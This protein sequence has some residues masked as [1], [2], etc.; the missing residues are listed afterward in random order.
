MQIK[1]RSEDDASS[2][3]LRNHEVTQR[4]NKELTCSAILNTRWPCV[5]RY[6]QH[7]WQ[8]QVSQHPWVSC[9]TVS[10]SLPSEFTAHPHSDPTPE[11]FFTKTDPAALRKVLKC[12]VMR[13]TGVNM[14]T[15]WDQKHIRVDED[16]MCW[17]FVFHTIRK[18][19]FS[20]DRLNLRSVTETPPHCATLSV[21]GHFQT[22][23]A[24]LFFFP[25]EHWRRS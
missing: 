14:G 13:M 4:L 24:F 5:T 16:M 6:P 20:F 3:G 9:L 18:M 2:S 22:Q 10:K 23:H 15:L 1:E 12:K 8:N 7:W 17:L 21:F 11:C 25:P 19:L